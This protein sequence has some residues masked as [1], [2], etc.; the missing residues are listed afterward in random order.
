MKTVERKISDSVTI[1]GFMIYCLQVTP[2]GKKPYLKVF[3]TPEARRAYAGE[4]E[5]FGH[6]SMIYFQHWVSSNC[7]LNEELNKN[8]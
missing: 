7:S 5:Q 6:Y 1:Y 3:E 4:I 2:D 8:N